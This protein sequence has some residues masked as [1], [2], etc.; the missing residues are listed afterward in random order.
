MQKAKL[1]ALLQELYAWNPKLKNKEEE[2]IKLIELMADSR[3]NTKFDENFASSLK[4]DLLSHQIL[5]DD[6][7]GLKD[8]NFL[9]NLKN[10]NK[11]IYIVAGAVAVFGLAVLAIMLNTVPQNKIASINKVISD[12]VATNTVAEQMVTVG[13]NAF[14]SLALLSSAGT[15]N[16]SNTATKE[17]SAAP[18]ARTIS[19]A[20]SLAVVPT[21]GKGVGGT[22]MSSKMIAPMYSYSYVYKGDPLELNDSTSKVYRRIKGD[23]NLSSDLDSLISTKAFGPINLNSF[24]DLQTS[25]ISL[26]ENK[27]LGLNINIDFK[28]EN[29]YI[30]QNWTQWQSDRDKCGDNQAC[31]DS[32]RI[33]INDI[34]EDSAVIKL[35]NDFLLAKGISLDHYGEAKV[36][37]NWRINYETSTDKPN[38]YIPEEVSVIYPL[39]VDGQTVY[40]QSG[41]LDGL[42]VNFNLLQ[43]AVS[44]VNNLTSYRYETS[45]YALEIDS[46]K[47][48]G[49]AEKGGY[50]SGIYYYAENQN[51]ITLE[52]GTPTKSL[53]H[54]W[55]Y[56]NNTNEELLIPALI[57]PINNIPADY[58]GSRFITVPL[59]QDMVNEL[60]NNNSGSNFGGIITPMMK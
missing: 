6:D 40:D 17:S 54:L 4:K 28:E 47:I 30:G 55:R 46:S 60:I 24:S 22:A 58:Y 45:D 8:N 50:G 35:T 11:K 20:T 12:N 16:V 13:P 48:L 9:F 36:D 31:W 52:L 1:D 59:V 23:G 39:S 7:D 2:L 15:Q 56:T 14:G 53:I 29:I 27:K 34:P 51:K 26:V 49:L 25:N 38:Y 42:R 18:T 37:N 43:H 44:G 32:Y 19:D 5:L 57:F 21:I 10:M 41:N 3:P 33:K